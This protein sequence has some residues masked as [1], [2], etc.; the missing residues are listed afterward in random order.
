MSKLLAP[1]K[2]WWEGQ[3]ERH[4]FVLGTLS[5]ISFSMVMWSIVFFFFLDGAQVEDL[6]HLRTGTWVGL[7]IGFTALIFIGPEFIHYQGQWSYLMQTLSLTS[8]AELGRERKEA[9]EAAQTLGKVWSARLKAH[10]IEHGL[11]RGRSAPEEADHSV[12][13]DLLINWWATDDSRLSRLVNVEMFRELWFNRSVAFV[14]VSG[15]LMQLYNMIWG[16]ATSENGTREN[17]LHIWEFL[18]GTSPGSYTAPYFDD[19]S[20]WIFLLITGVMMWLSFP[21]PGDRP[22]PPVVEEEE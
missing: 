7:F 16:I 15:F 1:F 21:A 3:R 11:L 10:Y 19:I 2:N 20:G 13:E 9:E 22:E 4:L 5:F 17:T 14:S 6:E 18:N 12:P 8:R